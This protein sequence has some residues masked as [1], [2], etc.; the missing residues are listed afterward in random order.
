MKSSNCTT[1]SHT[2]CSPETKDRKKSEKERERERER[3]RAREETE[4]TRSEPRDFGSE[5][6]REETRDFFGSVSS[7]RCTHS[8]TA[9]SQ[10]T[11]GTQPVNALATS[12]V[13]V[14]NNIGQV[15]T[16]TSKNCH[17]FQLVR[18]ELELGCNW[19]RNWSLALFL[20]EP[21]QFPVV[22]RCGARTGIEIWVTRMGG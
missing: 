18:T 6:G 2:K 4:W 10:S 20:E 21:D 7:G 8:G 22:I 19:N 12:P 16:L 14:H 9:G 17:R 3:A 15:P 11:K 13:V 1:Q 5:R